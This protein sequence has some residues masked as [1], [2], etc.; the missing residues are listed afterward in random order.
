MKVEFENQHFHWNYWTTM[1]I[2]GF[3]HEFLHLPSESGICKGNHWRNHRWYFENWQQI[4]TI[5]LFLGCW[6]WFDNIIWFSPSAL[7]LQQTVFEAGH[8]KLKM[9]KASLVFHLFE[10]KDFV[11]IMVW[12]F[13]ASRKRFLWNHGRFWKGQSGISSIREKYFVSI[14]V[15]YFIASATTKNLGNYERLWKGQSGISSSRE[16][17]FGEDRGKS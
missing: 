12:Y 17:L 10:K 2:F 9:E 7:I 5:M 8:T 13:I 6:R 15:W 4:K 14:M 16:K 1:A 11:T 3:W